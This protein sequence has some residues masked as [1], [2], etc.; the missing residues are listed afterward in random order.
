MSPF[1]LGKIVYKIL[2][3]QDQKIITGNHRDLTVYDNIMIQP[4]PYS[5]LQPNDI[6]MR[7]PRAEVSRMIP[8]ISAVPTSVSG[9]NYS[10]SV[11][12]ANYSTSGALNNTPYTDSTGLQTIRKDGKVLRP[13]NA[14]MLWAKPMRKELIA[15]G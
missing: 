6:E 10:T 5:K 15:N 9:A 11:S 14:F 7:N 12:G 3:F 1:F 13:M 8:G 4:D 2:F